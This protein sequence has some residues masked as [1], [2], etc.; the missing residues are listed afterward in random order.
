MSN[1]HVNLRDYPAP[2]GV[3]DTQAGELIMSNAAKCPEIKHVAPNPNFGIAELKGKYYTYI[4]EHKREK[5][6]VKSK[7]D[8]LLS[9]IL[10]AISTP[11]ALW[12]GY[13]FGRADI[14]AF[15]D[16]GLPLALL[17]ISWG[18]VWTIAYVSAGKEAKKIL[19]FVYNVVNGNPVDS[20]VEH[21]GGVSSSTLIGIVPLLIG[22]VVLI[23]FLVT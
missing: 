8:T 21:A 2:S 4:V 6:S 10:A 3:N 7:F 9:M 15:K 19:S 12:F 11:F 23:A 14:I 16:F 5:I 18:I 13:A 1:T 22:I 20:E 17:L